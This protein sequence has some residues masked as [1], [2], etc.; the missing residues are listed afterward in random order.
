MPSSGWGGNS[1]FAVTLWIV[2][3]LAQA[4][5]RVSPPYFCR[6]DLESCYHLWTSRY[7]QWSYDS[8]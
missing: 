1:I 8:S 6:L 7:S 5:A 2:A 4:E 3:R